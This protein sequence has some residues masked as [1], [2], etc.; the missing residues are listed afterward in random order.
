MATEQLSNYADV[1]AK[2]HDLLG[3]KVE[4]AIGGTKREPPLV[5]YFDGTLEGQPDLV[6]GERVGYHRDALRLGVGGVD[7][8]IHPDQF[9]GATWDTLTE[10]GAAVRVLRLVLG[11][12]Q[13]VFRTGP[14]AQPTS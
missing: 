2:L 12:V 1:L 5:A 8:T 7:I 11:Q 13:L 10:S 4:V 3:S 9:R 14:A 6:G